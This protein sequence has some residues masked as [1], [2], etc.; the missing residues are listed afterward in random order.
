LSSCVA[1][2]LYSQGFAS[3][4][5]ATTGLSQVHDLVTPAVIGA[6]PASSHHLSQA[7]TPL[8]ISRTV[9]GTRTAPHGLPTGVPDRGTALAS[10]GIEHNQDR[11]CGGA[12]LM[13]L[14]FAAAVA[15]IHTFSTDTWNRLMFYAYCLLVMLYDLHPVAFIAIAAALAATIVLAVVGILSICFVIARHIWRRLRP[16]EDRPS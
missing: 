5:T 4:E 1:E 6:G 8:Y 2:T 15:P 10:E 14:T 11:L 16:A 7:S 3:N 13:M 9:I 12:F